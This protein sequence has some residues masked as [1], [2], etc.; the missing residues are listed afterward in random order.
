MLLLGL[1]VLIQLTAGMLLHH[2][3]LLARVVISRGWSH[4]HLATELLL[5][6]EHLRLVVVRLLPP[7]VRLSL[8]LHRVLTMLL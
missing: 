1:G 4:T 6:W 5:L 8:L 2:V 7:W 3:L